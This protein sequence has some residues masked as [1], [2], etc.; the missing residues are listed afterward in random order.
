MVTTEGATRAYS[1]S[2]DHAVGAADPL[3][4][5]ASAGAA[6]SQALAKRKPIAMAVTLAVARPIATCVHTCQ[7]SGLYRL[8]IRF[9]FAGMDKKR[10][11]TSVVLV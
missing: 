1:S 7:R 5:V 3:V 4:S 10:I 11:K 2:G 9:S 6:A 8:D